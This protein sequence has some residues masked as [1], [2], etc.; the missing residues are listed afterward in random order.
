MRSKQMNFPHLL[1]AF[2]KS[3]GGWIALSTVFALVLRCSLNRVDFIDFALAV[4]LVASWPLL[5]WIFH[6]FLMHEWTA[7]PF[8]LTHDRH[9]RIPTAAT[10][11]PDTWIVVLYFFDTVLI[12]WI[13]LSYISTLNVAILFM[14]TAYEFVHFACHCNY[15]PMTA[16]GWKIR[17]NHLQHHRLD[18]SQGYSMLFPSFRSRR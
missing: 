15:K 16:W 5:E 6:R 4:M 8:H 2:G 7:L 18:E 12:W 10:G 1:I 11:L 14:L 3:R 17:I 9:H 13:G